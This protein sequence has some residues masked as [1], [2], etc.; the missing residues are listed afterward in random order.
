MQLLTESGKGWCDLQIV[1]L[2]R[3]NTH[4]Q[5]N[6]SK[7]T[8]DRMSPYRKGFRRDTARWQNEE[9]QQDWSCPGSRL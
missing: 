6:A 5:A 1:A 4:W 9:M 2:E 3:E 8:Q 7:S